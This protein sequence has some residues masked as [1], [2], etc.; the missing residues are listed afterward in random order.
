[1]WEFGLLLLLV[2]VLGLFLAQRFVPRGP[3]GELLNGTL[4]VTGVS[5]RPD[6]SGEQYVTLAGVINGPTVNEH[7][8]YWRLVVDVDQ[9]PAMGEL[10]PVVYSPKNPDNW[11]FAP[12]ESPAG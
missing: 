3:R 10:H 2:A 12:P 6:V 1:M 8:V 7:P 4:L 5:P 9:W 11:K